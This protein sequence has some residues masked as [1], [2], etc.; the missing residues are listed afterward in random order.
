MNEPDEPPVRAPRLLAADDLWRWCDRLTMPVR[1]RLVRESGTTEHI[2]VPCLLDQLEADLA[3]SGNGGGGRTKPGSRPPVDVTILSLM[4]EMEV[5]LVDALVSDGLGKR[6][7]LALSLRAVTAHVASTETPDAVDWWA[8]LVKGWAG[9][10]SACLPGENKD[11]SQIPIRG[12]QC[13][14]CAT[15]DIERIEGAEK[16]RDPAV[17]LVLNNGLT[18]YA[19]C[20]ACGGNWLRGA[21]LWELA[22]RAEEHGLRRIA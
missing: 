18:R 14:D 7:T 22:E 16:F 21:P 12:M 4:G 8:R 6:A 19:L 15:F 20:R 3:H 10:V 9:E 13:P 11:S 2:T 17:V 5:V 1:H